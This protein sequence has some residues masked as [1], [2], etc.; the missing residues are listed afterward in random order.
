MN[1]HREWLQV[2]I[3]L[4]L[5]LIILI[6]VFNF[7]V[8]SLGIYGNKNYLSKAAK[9][10]TDGKIIAGLKNIDDRLFQEL[11]I[12][13]LQDL[14][15]VIAIGSS[16]SM[17]LRREFLLKDDLNFFNHSLSGA[18]LEDYIAIIGAY[19]SIHGYLPSEVILGIDPW[20]FNENN[21]QGRW[22]GLK[23]YYE[24]EIEKIYLKKSKVNNIN[25][26]TEDL[27]KW[28][29]LVNFDTTIANIKFFLRSM[30]NNDGKK[31]YVVE[32]INIDDFIRSS[33]GSIHYPHSIR[34]I[35]DNKVKEHAISFATIKPYSLG[36]FNKLS[37]Q[38]LFE[39]FVKYL[40]K[41]NVEVSIFLPPYNPI[42]YDLLLESRKYHN[43]VN[44]EKYLINFSKAYSI[45][46][47]GSYNPHKLLLANTDFLDGVHGRDTLI[48]NI[49]S[50]F[51]LETN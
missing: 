36:K 32:D 22:K 37:N 29:Q 19:E 13:N 38:T 10:L 6:S 4:F 48:E 3:G 27:I 14:N 20:V 24:Y 43:I 1:K 5:L 31:F 50:N 17:Q 26:L 28:K 15:D 8:D 46:L 2:S 16:T 41:N 35:N 12:K 18:S 40:E 23:K 34:Y 11:I 45:K 7:K 39:D 44:V 25:K 21:N 47:F 30:I 33:D 51:M 9:T 49:F 42:A